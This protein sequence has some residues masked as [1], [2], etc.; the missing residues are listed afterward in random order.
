MINFLSDYTK[1]IAVFLIFTSLI[2]IFLPSNKYKNYINLILGF[3]LILLILK[4]ISEIF[5]VNNFDYILNKSVMSLEHDMIYEDIRASDNTDERVI[6]VYKN[7]LESQ[8]IAMSKMQKDF[9]VE[10]VSI[11]IDE[12]EESFGNILNIE[13]TVTENIQ[14]K[15][16]KFIKIEPVKIKNEKDKQE[17]QN[18]KINNLK[19]LYKDF[20]NLSVTNIN[21]K[22]RKK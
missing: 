3:I 17:I 12:R 1:T 13:L 15:D 2:G 6:A 9:I 19:N 20:Y 4:P 18:E 21:V 11:L 7:N 5:M 10:E 8:I 22:V 16:E 14:K